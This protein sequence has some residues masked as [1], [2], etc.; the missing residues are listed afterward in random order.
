MT[1]VSRGTPPRPRERS[2]KKP[3][4]LGYSRRTKLPTT[5]SGTAGRRGVQLLTTTEDP[6]E[7]TNWTDVRSMRTYVKQMRGCDKK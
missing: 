5:P 6:E 2:G 7:L 3:V 1:Q 4:V